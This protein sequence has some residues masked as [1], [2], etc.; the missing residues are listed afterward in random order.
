MK[1][2][3]HLSEIIKQLKEVAR[4]ASSGS[5]KEDDITLNVLMKV[6]NH[7]L[8]IKST[9]YNI[10]LEASIP[11]ADAEEDGV[12]AV[13]A[14]KLVDVCSRNSNTDNVQFFDDETKGVLVINAD[15]TV[16]EVWT[17]SAAEFPSFADEDEV[18]PLVLTQKQLK[19]L[20][21]LSIF[22][23]S[24]EDFREYLRGV[25]FEA[26]GNTLS[27]FSSDGHRM[28]I[29]DTQIPTTVA[30]PLGALLTKQG[31]EQISSIIDGSS[32][33]NVELK[34]TKN[35]V[36]VNCNGYSLK[37]KLITVPYPNVR[38]IVPTNMSNQVILPRKRFVELINRVSVLSSK[39]VNGVMFSF[40]EGKCDLKSENREHEVATHTESVPFSGAPIEIALNYMYI[41]D[42][43]SHLTT[44]NVMIKFSEP[45]TSVVISP[46]FEKDPTP[47]EVQTQYIIS[48]IVL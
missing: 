48:K 43:L 3:V 12:I 47:D 17:R 4:L 46:V 31:T 39:R 20:I 32:D 1:F 8:S 45:L 14:S 6:Q 24:N 37:S 9:D 44:D 41:N 11:L 10:E 29:L 34:F 22:C 7:V 25:R 5:K 35:S 19:K 21:D 13:N 18:Q 23:V 16:Y 33:S 42:C 28:A 27:V 2:S 36:S 38:N 30:Q 26:E 15:N 40:S